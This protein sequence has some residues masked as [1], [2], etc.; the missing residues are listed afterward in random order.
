MISNFK[1]A[2]IEDK[3]YRRMQR[4]LPCAF[5]GKFIPCNGD[6]VGAHIRIGSGAGMGQKPEDNRIVPACHAHHTLQHNKGEL[7]FH[8]AF[9]NE[10]VRLGREIWKQYM[11][12]K[13]DEHTDGIHRNGLDEMKRLVREFRAKTRRQI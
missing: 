5:K 6:V 4:L 11:T 1:V 9:L 7:W 2:R 10:A 3:K 8:G 12:W 13:S